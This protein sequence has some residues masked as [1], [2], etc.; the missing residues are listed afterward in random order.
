MSEIT[1]TIGQ[2]VEWLT[3]PTPNGYL[4]GTVLQ[5]NSSKAKI[6]V[7]SPKTGEWK[8]KWAELRC[9]R[10]VEPPINVA[11]QEDWQKNTFP[12]ESLP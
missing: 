5:V 4:H 2:E 10:K 9:L 8:E 6:K 12:G 11:V 3:R 7:Q 1:W